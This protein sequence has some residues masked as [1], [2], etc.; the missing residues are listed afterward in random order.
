MWDRAGRVELAGLKSRRI[1]EANIFNNGTYDS[2][3]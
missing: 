3:H 2:I 1:A